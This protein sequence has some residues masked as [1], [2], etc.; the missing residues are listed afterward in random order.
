MSG[1]LM[2]RNA[3]VVL[4]G[5]TPR[6]RFKWKKRSLTCV[7]SDKFERTVSVIHPRASFD[8]VLG[9]AQLCGRTLAGRGHPTILYIEV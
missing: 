8:L 3:T 5:G 6:V 9:A 7:E 1:V 2:T 4:D